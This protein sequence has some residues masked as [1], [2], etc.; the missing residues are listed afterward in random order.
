MSRSSNHILPGPLD[1]KR[2]GVLGMIFQVEDGKGILVSGRSGG[3]AAIALGLFNGLL[4]E[5][6][7]MLLLVASNNEP[8]VELFGSN[9]P[10]RFFRAQGLDS[11]Q[12]AKHNAWQ[13]ARGVG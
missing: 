6:Q 12:G 13:Q 5:G 11:E 3:G 4:E 7:Q 10:V 8:L 1:F 2:G 9:M